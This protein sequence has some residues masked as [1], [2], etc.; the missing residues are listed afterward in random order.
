MEHAFQVGYPVS[1]ATPT[2]RA[3]SNAAIRAHWLP[4]IL[5]L[6]LLGLTWSLRLWGLSQSVTA[7]DQDWVARAADF[8]TAVERHKLRDTY[9]SAHPGVP[10][11]WIASLVISPQQRAQIV[12]AGDDREKLEQSPAYLPALMVVRSTLA[13]YTAVLTLAL[14]FLTWRL[15]GAGPGLLA[16]LLLAAEPFLVAH[17]QLF[18]TD[19]LLALLMAISVLAALIYFD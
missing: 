14:A 9:Q 19:S 1:V 4:A 18:S 8:A 3:G 16:G 2:V 15:F 11:L 6:A 17:A 13:G 12:R 5:G 10:L 7:D